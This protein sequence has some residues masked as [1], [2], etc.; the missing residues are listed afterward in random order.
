MRSLSNRF[1]QENGMPFWG[2]LFLQKKD[3]DN[4]VYTM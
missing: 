3:V 4:V 1:N 2:I